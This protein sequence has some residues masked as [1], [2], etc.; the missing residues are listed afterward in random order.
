MGVNPDGL[1]V[2]LGGAPDILVS[3]PEGWQSQWTM[4]G[5]LMRSRGLL[6]DGC[7]L[8]EVRTLTRSRELPPPF[9]RGERALW[10]RSPDGAIVRARLPREPGHESGETTD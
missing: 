3:D 1:D 4:L 10:L 7:S 9:P 5:A 6:F 8:A 2:S